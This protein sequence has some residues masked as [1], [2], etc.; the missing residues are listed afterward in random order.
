MGTMKAG[1]L[2][3]KGNREHSAMIMLLLSRW[4]GWR[5]RDRVGLVCCP[6]TNH[7]LLLNFSSIS[8][9]K[10][11]YNWNLPIAQLELPLVYLFI[12]LL[13]HWPRFVM[14]AEPLVCVWCSVVVGRIGSPHLTL[15]AC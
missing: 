8:L 6:T 14:T 1:K 12:Y 15:P 5:G 7:N 3:E 13:F 10:L 11:N 2:R 4:L 9:Y